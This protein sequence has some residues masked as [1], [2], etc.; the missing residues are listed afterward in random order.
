MS[1]FRLIP[2]KTLKGK[3]TTL[4]YDSYNLP[5]ET[6]SGYF[7]LEDAN[8]QP[9]SGTSQT[10]GLEGF[11]DREIYKIFTTTKLN[12]ADD[13][14]ISSHADKIEL[15]PNRWFTVIKVDSW[16]VG[17]IPHYEAIVADIPE[18]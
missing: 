12:V 3:R 9:V 4:S 2:R 1:R 10:A 7:T 14:T 6:D 18:R 5:I 17:V 13:G 15:F 11:R 16:T 8:F